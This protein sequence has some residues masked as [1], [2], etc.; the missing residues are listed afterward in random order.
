MSINIHENL[1]SIHGYIHVIIGVQ[2]SVVIATVVVSCSCVMFETQ[3]A[4]PGSALG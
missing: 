1:I 2:V 4:P 3:P